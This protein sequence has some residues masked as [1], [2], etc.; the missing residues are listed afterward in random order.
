[1]GDL[2]MYLHEMGL[3]DYE[4]DAYIALLSEETGTA[5]EVA[6]VADIPQ[7]RVYDILEKLETKG[8]VVIQPGRP[9]KFGAVRP[10]RAIRQFGEF[11][12]RMFEQEYESLMDAGRE[13]VELAETSHL[14]NHSPGDPDIIWS[15]HEEHQL[16]EVF[17]Q[18]CRDA[19]EQIRM[20]TRANSIERKV[21]RLDEKLSALSHQGVELRVLIPESQDV[22]D[23]VIER[24]SEFAD[25]RRGTCI[26]A[27]IY[28]FDSTNVLIAFPQNDQY[29]GLTVHNE[30]LVETLVHM[31][32]E[33]WAIGDQLLVES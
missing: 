4:A 13:F 7:S 20:I 11:K 32:E 9:K 24:L 21:G 1:M 2:T 33:Q 17:G 10:N 6:T 14:N 29:V 5:K 30:P 12:E 8:F 16:F 18:L 27:Q 15:Y 31:F 28:L 23:V 22:S 19:T 25:V 3:S 26:E